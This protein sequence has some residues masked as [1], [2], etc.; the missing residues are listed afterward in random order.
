MAGSL[1]GGVM[2]NGTGNTG[3]AL[4]SRS[5]MGG[6]YCLEQQC[7]C[8]NI[9]WGHSVQ[10]YNLQGVPLWHLFSGHSIILKGA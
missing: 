1:F 2:G 3:V 7:L 10:N 6:H 9:V 8:G 4:L 5:T